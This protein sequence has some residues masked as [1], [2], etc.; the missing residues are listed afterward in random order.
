MAI[1]DQKW[2]KGPM[3]GPQKGNF[4]KMMNENEKSNIFHQTTYIKECFG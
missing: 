1:F 4:G 2:Q 3:L